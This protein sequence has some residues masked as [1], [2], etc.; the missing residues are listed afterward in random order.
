[1]IIEDNLITLESAVLSCMI[2]GDMPDAYFD[3]V[4]EEYITNSKNKII[5][6]AIKDL[7]TN[8]VELDIVSV[9]NKLEENG[10]IKAIGGV[11]YLMNISYMLPNANNFM[12]YLNQ[13]KETQAKQKTVATLKQLIKE[14]DKVVDP[15]A[16]IA[17]IPSRFTMPKLKQDIISFADVSIELADRVDSYYNGESIFYKT[18]LES[19]DKYFGGGIQSGFHIIAART[20]H[21]KTELAAE[22]ALRLA[23]NGTRVRYDQ[24]EL[25]G[26]VFFEYLISKLAGSTRGALIQ[27]AIPRHKVEDAMATL[28]SLPI[29]TT[30]E[31][32]TIAEYRVSMELTKGQFDVAFVDQFSHVIPNPKID[33][34]EALN[35]IVYGVHKV[36]K[37]FDIPTFL[38]AQINREPEKGGKPRKPLLSDMKS[39]G[40][41]EETADV[42]M[43]LE[44]PNKGQKNDHMLVHID[45]DRVMQNNVTIKLEKRGGRLVEVW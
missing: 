40:A 30:T 26:K 32:Y 8:S 39:S 35:E 10:S 31:N 17:S 2:T 23:I 12:S 25:T 33:R 1:M 45:K 41:L 37:D 19:F 28:S 9:Y 13:I 18:G 36:S 14:S 15:S 7:K 11:D 44:R 16:W 5:L 24:L 4:T 34:L 20:N 6:K 38:L 43:I 3:I 29:F 42:V 27:G 21:G 22:L